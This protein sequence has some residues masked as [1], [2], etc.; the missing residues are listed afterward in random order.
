MGMGITNSSEQGESRQVK[1]TG[2]QGEH[3]FN[4]VDGEHRPNA[5]RDFSSASAL[6]KSVHCM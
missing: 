4:E 3:S 5:R 2:S 1:G 6:Y